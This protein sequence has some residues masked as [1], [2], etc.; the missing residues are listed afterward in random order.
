MQTIIGISIDLRMRTVGFSGI[1]CFSAGKF[2]SAGSVK[3]AILSLCIVYYTL[4][5][6]S[7]K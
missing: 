2:P 7:S 6:Y 4:W 3:N 5:N 1:D